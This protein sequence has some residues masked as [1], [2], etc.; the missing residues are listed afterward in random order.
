VITSALVNRLH[1]NNE[2]VNQMQK[3]KEEFLA[4]SAE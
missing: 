1:A 3:A 4:K 2:F